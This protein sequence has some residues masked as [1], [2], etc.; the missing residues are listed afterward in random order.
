[1]DLHNTLNLFAVLCMPESPTEALRRLYE[2]AEHQQGLFTTKQAKAAG[3]AE[4]TRPYHV[5]AGNWIPEHRGIYRLA[6]FSSD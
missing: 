2:V 6:L 5:Q 4:N 3:R 1:M